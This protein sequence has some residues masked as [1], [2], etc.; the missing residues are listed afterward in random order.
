[1]TGKI[2]AH[3]IERQ[4][5]VYVRQSSA[6]QVF[7]NTESTARQ[8]ALA[9]RARALGWSDDAVQII[10][11]DLG[12]S[13]AT[14]TNRSGFHRLAEAVARGEVGAI[15]AIEV[16]RLARSSQDW[17]R[18]LALCAVARVVVID[19]H[20][21]Y[22]PGSCDD[23]ILLDFKGTMSEAELHW[24]GLR[25]TGAR[26]SK[27]KRGE[28]RL[29]PATGYVWSGKGFEMDPDEAVRHA[30]R[31]IFERF[32]IEPTAWAV[33]RWAHETGFLMPT[34]RSFADGTSEVV[35][36]PLG[37]A[38]LSDVLHNPV[39]AGAYV[40]G[41]RPEKTVLVGGEIRSVRQ[42]NGPDEWAIKLEHA[43]PAYISWETYLSNVEKLRKNAPRFSSSSPPREGPA[44]LGGILICGRCGRRMRTS[45]WGVRDERWSY[46]CIGE[47]D[48]GERMCWS[49]AGT[50]V[51]AA[52][53]D[54][55]LRTMVPS[56]LE[57]CLAVEREVHAQA[58]SLDQQWKLHVEK[59]DYEARRAER[60]YKAVD[61][62]NRVVARTLETEW[63]VRLREL[64]D[65]RRRYE[66][67][68]RERHTALSD[69]DRERVRS[70]AHDLPAV[71]RATTTKV[72][73]RKAMLRVVIEA[74]SVAPIDVP[75]RQ[76]HVKVQWKSGTVTELT[77]DRPARG[78]NLRTPSHTVERIVRLA[79]DGLRDEVIADH[80]EAEGVPTGSGGRWN[81]DAVKWIR[82]KHRI[83]RSFPDQP[84]SRPLPDRHPADGRYSIRGAMKRFGVSDTAVRRWIRRGMVDAAREDF[85][86]HRVVYWLR[87]DEEM[88][89]QLLAEASLSRERVRSQA[90]SRRGGG[91]AV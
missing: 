10:D 3:H 59:A 57:L 61:P 82:Q 23:K 15:L 74:V 46:S 56:E 6:A 71:W 67:A 50:P 29:T 38:R 1:M 5:Y 19:E 62:D 60:R 8:Y 52:V 79:A 13:G 20:A 9:E 17:H 35:W 72:A 87:I 76:T 24:L 2:Q 40:Y 88:E 25:M 36:K 91:P 80:L 84:R 14:A 37:M 64:E 68:K 16:S 83:P 42:H 55:F 12:R 86:G 26:R 77:I 43:H 81:R 75:E 28:L 30:V 54:L 48:H 53:E 39:Y 18:L 49:V 69:S 85:A 7:E 11:E 70:L 44:L 89:K 32:S 63:E 66:M 41:R 34:R 4:A 27:A 58:A 22:D 33:V 47:K 90:R 31:M 45:Y 21:V 78:D 51:D 65:V 73:D